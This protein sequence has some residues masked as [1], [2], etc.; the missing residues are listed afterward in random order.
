M[1]AVITQSFEDYVSFERQYESTSRSAYF[2]EYPCRHGRFFFGLVKYFKV[3]R[4]INHFHPFYYQPFSQ[5]NT[6]RDMETLNKKSC[7]N[8]LQVV[9]TQ[10]LTTSLLLCSENQLPFRY[11]ANVAISSERFEDMSC[12][13]TLSSSLISSSSLTIQLI[14]NYLLPT[15]QVIYSNRY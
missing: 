8:L 3:H 11:Y 4:Q 14:K 2:T 13:E 5:C 7:Y 12:T 6:M 15:L 1:F 9:Q 10:V